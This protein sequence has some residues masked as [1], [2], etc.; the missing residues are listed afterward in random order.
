MKHSMIVAFLSL[1]FCAQAHGEIRT[2]TFHNANLY[3]DDSND[4]L[5]VGPAGTLTGRFDYD[6][7]NRTITSFLLDA[8]GAV[9]SSHSPEFPGCPLLN[10]VGSA[11]VHSPTKLVFEENLT[12]GANERLEVFLDKPL[13]LANGPVQLDPQS[14]IYY[15]YGRATIHVLGGSIAPLTG[16]LSTPEPATYA[17]MLIGLGIVGVFSRR[18]RLFSARNETREPSLS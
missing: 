4:A 10:C 14:V 11:S 15:Y 1:M 9:F 5:F 8:G 6:T 7:S 13:D 16:A 2:W 12:P 17:A 18:S 3:A